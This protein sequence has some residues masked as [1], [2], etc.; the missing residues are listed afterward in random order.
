MKLKIN[1]QNDTREPSKVMFNPFYHG[2][3]HPGSHLKSLCLV[4]I[5]CKSTLFTSFR[6]NNSSKHEFGAFQ[7]EVPKKISTNSSSTRHFPSTQAK[8]RNQ[9]HC[10]GDC[11][12]I[13]HPEKKTATGEAAGNIGFPLFLFQVDRQW[14]EVLA[15]MDVHFGGLEVSGTV[16]RHRIF[17]SVSGGGGCFSR[18]RKHE[19]FVFD[20]KTCGRFH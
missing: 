18:G 4:G 19:R 20:T 15:P 12:G 1:I 8:K 5:F 14:S 10:N 9:T 7:R 3:Q 13:T 6:L 16:F 11:F 2:I 17:F